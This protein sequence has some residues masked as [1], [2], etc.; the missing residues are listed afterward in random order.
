MAR[1]FAYPIVFEPQPSG[2]FVIS[3]PDL[4]ELL[5]EG[6]DR[7]DAIAQATDALEEVFAAR[8]RRAEEIPDPS[9]P[10]DDPNV[11]TIRVPPIMAAKAALAL[12][13]RETGMSQTGL[14]RQLG[15]DEKEVRRLLDPRH[16]SKLARLQAALLALNRDVEMRI[17][18]VATPEIRETH[19]RSYKAV[20][21][22]AES[23]ARKLFPRAVAAGAAIPVQELLRM[24]R[25][26]EALGAAATL[27]VDEAVREEAVSEFRRGTVSVR[28]RKDVW[29]GAQAG[30][31][32][33]RFTL[34]HELAHVILHR[35]DLEANRG[36]A[37]RDMVTATEKL[38]PDVPIYCSPEWQANAWAGAFLMPLAAVRAYLRKLARQQREFS[39]AAFAVHFQVSLQAASIRLQ[40]LLPELLVRN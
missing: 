33:F 5:T 23:L 29:Q 17:V 12:A 21:H 2:G 18:D 9:I 38:P 36:R 10:A 32:R 22:S 35:R 3:C 20:A 25:L 16:A 28:L 34:A 26:A 37:F 4:P 15:V 40:K 13:L 27:Q 8:I 6:S 1:D 11:V 31:A 14:S 24:P 39:H 19:A 7:A 30:N